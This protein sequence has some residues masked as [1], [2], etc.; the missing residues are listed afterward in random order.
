VYGQKLNWRN[1]QTTLTLAGE[2][3]AV[4]EMK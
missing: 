4:I 2:D 1:G 3:V